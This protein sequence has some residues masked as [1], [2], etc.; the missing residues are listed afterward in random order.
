M[1]KRQVLRACAEPR[2]RALARRGGA[3][4]TLC[5]DNHTLDNSYSSRLLLY[6]QL[7]LEALLVGIVRT[8]GFGDCLLI[9]IVQAIDFGDCL[10]IRIVQTTDFS[11]CLLIGIVQTMDFGDHLIIGIV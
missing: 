5:I 6:L 7:I 10:L 8:I 4:L 11:D 1:Y 9:R 3:R 2:R